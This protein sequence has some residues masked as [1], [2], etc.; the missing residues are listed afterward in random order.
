VHK[1]HDHYTARCQKVIT[2]NRV[3][4]GQMER[5]LSPLE[6]ALLRALL[7]NVL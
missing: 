3:W 5:F 7:G 1:A 2:G 6:N 4:V